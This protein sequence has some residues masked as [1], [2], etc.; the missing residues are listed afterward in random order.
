MRLPGVERRFCSQQNLVLLGVLLIG[1]SLV[2]RCLTVLLVLLVG[3]HA[4]GDLRGVGMKVYPRGEGVF[5]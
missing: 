4:G 3:V 5:V 1:K 2:N